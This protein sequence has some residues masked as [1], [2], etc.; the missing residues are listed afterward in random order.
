MQHVNRIAT[1]QR[2]E[3]S[4][5]QNWLFLSHTFQDLTVQIIRRITTVETGDRVKISYQRP[6]ANIVIFFNSN[7][8]E[9]YDSVIVINSN[10]QL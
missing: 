9:F 7:T 4:P 5:L 10:S 1:S 8:D 2:K 3:K 6:L